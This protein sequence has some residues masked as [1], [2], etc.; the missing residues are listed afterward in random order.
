M[1]RR[2]S[3]PT[4]QPARSLLLSPSTLRRHTLYVSNYGDDS[5]TVI[6]GEKLTATAK[7]PV[8]QKPQAVVVDGNTGLVYVANT[9]GDSVT[10][11]NGRTHAVVATL[12]AGKNPYGLALD[13]HTGS[14]Y[15]SN[16]ANPAYTYLDVK[17]LR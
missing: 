5:V 16:E 14:L 8:G 6:D 10:V 13:P 12:P 11:I 4:F 1:K 15:V 7:V 9:H 17:K 3:R 2:I